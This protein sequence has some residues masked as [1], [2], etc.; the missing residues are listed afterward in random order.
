M[1]DRRARGSRALFVVYLMLTVFLT[2]GIVMLIEIIGAR[3]IAPFFGS[4]IFVWTSV[5]AVTLLS[6]ALGYLAGGKVA[7]RAPAPHVLY[8]ATLASGIYLLLV[9]FI[10]K[11]TLTMGAQLGLKSGALVS[12]S[13]LFA[14][15]LFLLGT[16]SPFA[17]KLYTEQM[18]SLGSHVGILYFLSTIGSFLGTLL[19]G[20]IL[21]PQF[22]V[23]KI[24]IFT[25]N[26]LIGIS[27]VYF[28]A[29]SRNVKWLLAAAIA[30]SQVFLFHQEGLST[31]FVEGTRWQEVYKTDSLYGR[32]KVIE[33]RGRDRYLIMDSANQGG[34][35]I[36]SG[37]SVTLYSHVVDVLA[38][39][40]CPDMKNA[41][42]IGLG[43]GAVPN[44]FSKRGVHTDAVDI[45]PEVVRLYQRYFARY[46]DAGNV[47]LFIEDGRCFIRKTPKV[48]DVVVMDVFLGD[49]SPWH[50]L[51]REAFSEIKKV[52]TD[53]GVLVIN[54]ITIPRD[55][56]G[57]RIMGAIHK[58]LSA[59]FP[60]A[61]TFNGTGFLRGGAQN[62]FFLASL[63]KPSF[64]FSTVIPIPLGFTGKLEMVLH[65][66]QDRAADDAFL[67]TDDYNPVE[68]Y[69]ARAKE[70][71]RR[72]IVRSPEREIMCD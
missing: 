66:R 53:K 17:V 14:P 4:S 39:M 60:Y 13:I 7:D 58:T 70:A 9:L 3:V 21:I 45:D 65:D 10:K 52:L 1:S 71:W 20:F 57:V 50:L 28:L 34:V 44:S 33:A 19:A 18:E 15:P 11:A 56:L 51:T 40:A 63:K 48:Y 62:V 72:E 36:E 16:V 67:L 12:S 30:L 47:S 24:L 26:V 49:S 27:L 6:L 5:I 31:V 23:S 42:V 25:A 38:T 41:L 37:V 68:F 46:G 2:G 35:N 43:P 61:Y 29:F 22:G 32:L 59:E 8:G 64:N 54:F 69:N 55:A